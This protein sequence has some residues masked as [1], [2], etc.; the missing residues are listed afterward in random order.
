MR[1]QLLFEILMHL[2]LV[3]EVTVTSEGLLV[4]KIFSWSSLKS[5][6]VGNLSNF[7]SILY[8]II[9]HVAEAPDPPPRSL[10]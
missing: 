9:G 4:I 2:E 10:S 6:K 1:V 3:L 8:I 5:K 7:L